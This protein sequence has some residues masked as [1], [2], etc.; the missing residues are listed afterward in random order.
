MKLF[1]CIDGLLVGT[2]YLAW[3]ISFV[4]IVGSIVLFFAN[5]S[6][7]YASAAVFIASF[8][9]SVGVTLVLLPKM[10]AK[11]KLESDMKYVVGIVSI[12]VAAAVMGAIYFSNGGFPELN[13]IFA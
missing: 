6:I 13:L 8:F 12:V 9:L 4:G 2:K 1:E 7:G 10:F 11:G 3:A 5:L